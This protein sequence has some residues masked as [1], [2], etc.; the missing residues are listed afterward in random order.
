MV[1]VGAA[2]AEKT[3]VWH[4]ALYCLGHDQKPQSILALREPGSGR[5][6]TSEVAP[7]THKSLC[8][9]P[10]HWDTYTT[11]PVPLSPPCQQFFG[12]MQ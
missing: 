11:A 3:R 6:G 12:P 2:V 1:G 5:K 8:P 10:Y 4:L 9:Q 7:H